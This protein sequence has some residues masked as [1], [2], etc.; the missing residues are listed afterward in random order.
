[1][2]DTEAK[3]G[4]RKFVEGKVYLRDAKGTIWEYEAL[5]AKRPGFTSVIPNPVQAKEAQKEPAK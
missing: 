2:A 4:K 5:L 3:A 1:M